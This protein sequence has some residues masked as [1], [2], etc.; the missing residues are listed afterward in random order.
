MKNALVLIYGRIG[1]GKTLYLV[2]KATRLKQPIY[3]NFL[4]DLP[5]FNPL[6]LYDFPYLPNN[7]NVFID[8]GYVLS[9][10]RAS[11]SKLN[12]YMSHVYNQS[13]HRGMNIFL[14]TQL[15][16]AIDLRFRD[17]ATHTVYCIKR[18]VGFIY[19]IRNESNGA[20]KRIFLSMKN[21]QKYFNLYNTLQIVKPE[22]MKEFEVELTLDNPER[23]FQEIENVAKEIKPLLNEITHNSIEF[24]LAKKGYSKSYEKFVYTYL[25]GQVNH[26]NNK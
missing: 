8:E 24:A 26:E 16:S 22:S 9:D 23:M 6:H 19:R 3:S 21:A 15:Q 11:L 12:R 5:H 7:I 13:R 4:I 18:K 17:Q 14:T 10:S 2:Y 1:N 25:T 20:T